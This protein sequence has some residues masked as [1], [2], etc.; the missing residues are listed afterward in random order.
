MLVNTMATIDDCDSYTNKQGKFGLNFTIS[1][2]VG[3]K[4]KRL[5]MRGNDERLED[6]LERNIGEDVSIT[7][8]LSQNNFGT[9]IGDVI[10]VA[11][12]DGEELY[13]AIL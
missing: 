8:D 9:Q 7:F 12:V 5:D 1:N 13:S 4:T 3:R 11:T 10:Q 2:K 6:V